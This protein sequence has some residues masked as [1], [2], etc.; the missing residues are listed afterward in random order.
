MISALETTRAV[1]ERI[2]RKAGYT[3]L[4]KPAMTLADSPLS[5]SGMKVRRLANNLRK[6]MK[7]EQPNA[8]LAKD[9]VVDAKNVRG[10]VQLLIKKIRDEAID[11]DEADRLIK[12]SQQVAVS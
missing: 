4:L 10:V 2:A 1:I 12:E 5:L 11:N 3:L 7:D 8:S 9:E 6:M